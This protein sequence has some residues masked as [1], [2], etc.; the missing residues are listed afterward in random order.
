MGMRTA[1][2]A[3]KKAQTTPVNTTWQ[4]TAVRPMP[5]HETFTRVPAPTVVRDFSQIPLQTTACSPSI[6]PKLTINQPGDKYEEEADRIAGQIMRMPDPRTSITKE[7]SAQIQRAPLTIQRRAAHQTAPSTAPPIVHEVLSS[8]GRPLAPDTRAFMEPR[9]G[10]DFSQVRIHNDDKSSSSAQSIQAKAYAFTNHIVFDKSEFKPHQASGLHLIAHE[11]AHV[12]QQKDAT[13]RTEKENIQFNH[14]QPEPITSS[15]ISL[16]KEEAHSSDINI[17]TLSASPQQIALNRRSTRSQQEMYVSY[18]TI[19]LGSEDYIDFHTSQGLFRYHLDQD[20]LVPGEYRATAVVEG[21]DVNFT[22]DGYSGEFEFAY[23]IEPDQ[24]NPTDFFA[25]QNSAIF[26]IT[27][28]TAPVINESEEENDRDLS[29]IYLSIEEAMRRCQSGDLPGVKIFPYRGTRFG[30]AP[31]MAHRDG[32]DIIV[33]QPVYVL[34]NDDFREQTHTLP[35]E[36]FIGGIRLNPREIVRVHT[37]EPRWYH[38]NITGSTTGD[39]EE[40]FCA[41]GEQMLQIAEQSTNRTLLNI[42]LTVIDAATIFLPVGRLATMIGRPVAQAVGRSSRNIALAIMLGLRDASPTVFAGIASRSSIVLVEQQAVHQVSSRAISQTISHVTIE[43]GEHIAAQ[44]IPRT[45]AAEAGTHVATEAVA[46]TMTVTVVD[47][48]GSQVVSTLA[49]PTGDATVDA[50]IEQAFSQTFNVTAV[51]ATS[52]AVQQGVTAVAPEIAAGFAEA[53]VQAFS[54]FLAKPFSH[55]DIRILDQLWDDAARAGD[56]AILTAANSRQLFNLHRNRFWRRVRNN[57][58]A[59]AIFKNAGCQ[60]SGGAPY[61]MLNGRRIT[62]TIDHII[63]RQ[64]APHLALIAANLRISFSRE[65]TVVLRLL[66]QLD[67]FQ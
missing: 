65:N 64:S 41:T 31:I 46:R 1:V 10:R 60:F 32:E 7:A 47:A 66:N 20:G 18:V 12:A 6:Q 21:N 3:R 16:K 52:Q 44:T 28:E 50:M 45:M 56:D 54:R 42:G 2:E 67:P 14:I 49:S 53:E 35:T 25:G 59:R 9:F 38:L 30:G 34:S 58:D 26:T 61:Y 55:Q 48:T 51:Q 19:Y 39:I 5:E 40:E 11:L 22:F 15:H 8:P 63:E 4:H 17:S 62:M 36:T 33:K 24:P 57:P 43:F 29:T 37:Y 27:R 13:S 23:R